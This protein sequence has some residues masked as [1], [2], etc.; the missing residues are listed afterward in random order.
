MLVVVDVDDPVV[1][2]VPVPPE[3]VGGAWVVVDDEDDEP[4]QAASPMARAPRAIKTSGGRPRPRREVVV[5]GFGWLRFVLTQPSWRFPARQESAG[6]HSGGRTVGPHFAT[7][8]SPDPRPY[9][10]G[11]TQGL[12]CVCGQSERVPAGTVRRVRHRPS[13]AGVLLVR[14]RPAEPGSNPMGPP[15]A[16][17]GA[18]LVPE[19]AGRHHPLRHRPPVRGPPWHGRGLWHTRADAPQLSRWICPAAECGYRLPRLPE[20]SDR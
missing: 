13:R 8:P 7:G 19:P 9:H 10:R 12:T 4:P 16:G 17:L 3:V 18:H 15:L 1:E 14:S 2:V 6:P 5:D 20:A 11:G